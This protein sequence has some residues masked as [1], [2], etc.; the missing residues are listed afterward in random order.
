M[1]QKGEMARQDICE[2]ELAELSVPLNIE[3]EEKGRAG[4]IW[5]FLMWMNDWKRASCSK[6]MQEKTQVWR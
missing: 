3:S 1:A 5:G 2:V 4:G 6:E